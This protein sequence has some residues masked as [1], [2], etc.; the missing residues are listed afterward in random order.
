MTASKDAHNL[1]RFVDAQQAQYE[2]VCA[3]LRAGRK[4][5]HW[6]WFIF[7]QMRGLGHSEM[8]EF[9]GIAS[10]QEAQAYLAHP[11]LGPRLRYCTELVMNVEGRS[12]DD[13]FGFPDT[14]KFRSC[15]TLFASLAGDTQLFRNALQKYFGGEPDAKTLALL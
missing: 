2:Q 4:R 11:V 13:I 6:I 9:Y 3:E 5:S 12:A 7:P 15:M 8:A 14:L 10:R 1:Q